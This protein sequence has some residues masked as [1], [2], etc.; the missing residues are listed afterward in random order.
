MKLALGT[1]QIG[2]DYGVANTQGKV[3]P[4][5]ARR[6]LDVARSAGITMLDTAVA[7]GDSEARLGEIGITGC[8]VISKLPALPDEVTDVGGWARGFVTQSLAHLK[9]DRLYGVLLHRPLQLLEP[10]GA[11]LYAALQDLKAEGLVGKTGGSIHVVSDLEGLYEAYHLD[12]VQTPFNL[13]DTRL[14]TSGWMQRLKRGGTELH[15]RSI[16]LQGVLLYPPGRRPERFSRWADHFSAYDAWMRS[17]G[18]T[19]VEACV[20]YALSFP[21]IDKVVVGV[22]SA[23]QLRTIVEAASV[24]PPAFPA[25]LAS[26]DRDLLDPLVWMRR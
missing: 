15:V 1:A 18:R 17:H 8:D 26:D 6:I 24:H 25:S 23:A 7:Y 11:E 12:L 16:F 14:I 22:D 4:E 10:R 20:T 5:E 2:L 13:F 19:A 3:S 9:I 21:E